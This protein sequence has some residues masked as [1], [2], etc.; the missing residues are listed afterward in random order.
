MRELYIGQELVDGMDEVFIAGAFIDRAMALKWSAEKP[1]QR[2]IL[3]VPQLDKTFS[4]LAS[5]YNYPY[6]G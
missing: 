2:E 3:A 6:E 1:N 5:T 4:Q